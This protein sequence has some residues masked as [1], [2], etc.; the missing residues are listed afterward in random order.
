MGEYEMKYPFS[1]EQYLS[2]QGKLYDAMI[3]ICKEEKITSMDYKLIERDL[4]YTPNRDTIINRKYTANIS[5]WLEEIGWLKSN[6]VEEILLCLS[7]DRIYNEFDSPLKGILKYVNRERYLKLIVYDLFTFREKFSFLIYEV[8][9]R[10]IKIYVNKKVCVNNQI[11]TVKTL[12][13]LKNTEVSFKKVS[14]GLSI[15]DIFKENVSWINEKEFKLICSIVNEF[16]TNTYIKRLKDIRNAFTHR[17]NPGIDCLSLR[18][19]EY[20]E[21]DQETR[22]MLLNFD[23]SLGIENPEKLKYIIKSSKPLEKEEKFEKIMYDILGV[24][25]LFANSF[26]NLLTDV[27][28][29]KIEVDKLY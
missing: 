28:I 16:D 6:I 12:K 15:F 23:K 27:S 9:N 8:F 20:P 7:Y 3:D 19:Y 17:S 11:E 14:E 24:W 21:V 18:S 22:R 26:K 1:K 29:L 2:V 25:R 5:K 10:Q 13:Q 4:L